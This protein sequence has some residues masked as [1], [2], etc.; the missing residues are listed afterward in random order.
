M[1]SNGDDLS[2][3]LKNEDEVGRV[4]RAHIHIEKLINDFL[5]IA[6]DKPIHLKPMQL[7]YFGKVNLSACI[8]FP[9]ELKKPLLFMGKTRNDFAHNLNQKIDKSRVNDFFDTFS[10]LHKD[11]IVNTS[12][13]KSLSWVSE[14]KSWTNIDAKDKF[15]VMCFSLYYAI[16]IAIINFEAN[17]KIIKN[18]IQFAKL[19]KPQ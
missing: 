17:E 8:G 1:L 5:E 16:K 14:G 9:E 12:V 4:I 6:L 19:C 11:E 2:E 3:A 18:Q 15:M 13:N 7:D 10:H